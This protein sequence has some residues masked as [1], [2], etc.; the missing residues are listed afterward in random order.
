MDKRVWRVGEAERKR[1]TVVLSEE[2]QDFL[3]R[4]SVKLR[5]VELAKPRLWRLICQKRDVW[6]GLVR[7]RTAED[8]SR[9][10]CERKECKRQTRCSTS[11]G[12]WKDSGC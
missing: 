6:T 5:R 9:R 8:N 3:G 10:G 2:A 7:R 4:E 12:S 11:T 1:I